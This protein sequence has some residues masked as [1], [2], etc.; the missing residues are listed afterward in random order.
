M[1]LQWKSWFCSSCDIN[2]TLRHPD[3]GLNVPQLTL[4]LT[5]PW[6]VHV[7]VTALI[8]SPYM[9]VTPT[10]EWRKCVA[11]N[12]VTGAIT[13]PLAERW[14]PS[15]AL[16]EHDCSVVKNKSFEGKKRRKY[17]CTC[18]MAALS[19]G[20]LQP[21]SFGM[22]KHSWLVFNQWLLDERSKFHH[23]HAEMERK[24]P[25]ITD[26]WNSLGINP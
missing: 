5:L 15:P 2:P 26:N 19:G 6:Q 8:N 16:Y 13:V 14:P 21:S 9:S 18:N 20:E 11:A 25:S 3:V 7:L 17:Q 23:V 10:E 12:A 1:Q 4:L 22:W 24:T